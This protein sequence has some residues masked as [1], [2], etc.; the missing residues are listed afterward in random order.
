[1]PCE[2]IQ[3]PCKLSS[4]LCWGYHTPHTP[5]VFSPLATR[6]P[7]GLSVSSEIFQK[8]LCQALEGLNGVATV[9]EDILVYGIGDTFEEATIDHDAKLQALLEC[10]RKVGI[11]L[12][13]DKSQFGLREIQFLGHKIT[14][15]D[16]KADTSKVDALLK[17]QSPADKKGV[18]RFQAMVNYLARFFTSAIRDNGSNSFIVKG[19]CGMELECHP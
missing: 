11:Q 6:L 5:P 4:F 17:M 7:F 13:T 1:M 10:C 3:L 2:K 12:N 8:R 14:D 19:R 9:A 15:Q 18:A 16:L